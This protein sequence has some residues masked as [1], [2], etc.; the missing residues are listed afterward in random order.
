[1]DIRIKKYS[2]YIFVGSIFLIVVYT[3]G[4]LVPESNHFIRR[5]KAIIGYF[6]ALPIVL[7]CII[8]SIKVLSYYIS[9]K[10]IP[11]I[12]YFLMIIPFVVFM[13]WFATL[14]IL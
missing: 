12:K 13:I 2:I 5:L 10:S 9:R 1:M 7:I 6:I 11:S 14:L 4:P 3:I 8:L